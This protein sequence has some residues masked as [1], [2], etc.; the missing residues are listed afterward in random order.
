MTF[1]GGLTCS[2]ASLTLKAGGTNVAENC[3]AG[4][5]DGTWSSGP[6]SLPALVPASQQGNTIT[7][8]QNNGATNMTLSW[9]TTAGCLPVG[10][11]GGGN[12]G[13]NFCTQGATHTKC[14]SGGNVCTGSFDGHTAASP[15]TV[16]QA[17]TGAY[18]L[19]SGLTPA[20]GGFSPGPNSNSGTISSASVTDPS[21]NEIQTI[22]NGS[23]TLG[24]KITVTFYGFASASSISGGGPPFE[25]TLG[26]NQGNGDISCTGNN[27]KTAFEN[28]I[29]TG[30]AGA[31][32]SNSLQP[33]SIVCPAG[34]TSATPGPAT[35]VSTNPGG[36]KA[37]G[38]SNALNV[39]I[40]GGGTSCTSPNHWI[41]PNAIGDV[42]ASGDPR[43]IEVFLTDNVALPN[44]SGTDEPIRGFAEF[45][46]TGWAGLK[47]NGSDPCQTAPNGS[48]VQG[49]T[50]CPGTLA[51]TADNLPP[52]NTDGVVVGHFVTF[53]DIF[54]IPTGQNCVAGSLNICVPVLTK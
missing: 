11:A 30:C 44:G 12:D 21:G 28:A 31:Y 53:I 20:A 15:E 40:N 22:A 43:L 47:Q 36:G 35:C 26:G 32:A 2:Q 16:Q 7:P 17:Y 25:F 41:S 37:F 38:I 46:I 9:S 14:G 6:I 42:L 33:P 52:D 48:Y 50:P 3:P 1:G 19:T 5:A 45:Y 24:D 34:S 29:E 4:G 23:N 8:A 13:S 51:C 27:G 54:G 18:S 10:A 49:T 39:K